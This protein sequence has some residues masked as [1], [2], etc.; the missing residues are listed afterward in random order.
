MIFKKS[1]N[2]FRAFFVLKVDAIPKFLRMDLEY[3]YL[4]LSCVC[5]EVRRRAIYRPWR[6][7]SLRAGAIGPPHPA[8]DADALLPA[9]SCWRGAR[10]RARGARTPPALFA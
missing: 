5:G 6:A 10:R 9:A 4:F 8:D 2:F 3:L 1:N 7:R